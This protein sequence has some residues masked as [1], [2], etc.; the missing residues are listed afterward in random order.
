M[1]HAILITFLL[2]SSAVLDRPRSGTPDVDGAWGGW[3]E[4]AGLELWFQVRF[5]GDG[6]WL[7]DFEA[8]PPAVRA[9]EFAAASG[10]AR[11]VYD[12]PLGSIEFAG[13]VEG[14]R[15]SG[16]VTCAGLD[17]GTFE[18]TRFHDVANERILGRY[19][20]TEGRPLWVVPRSF[21]GARVVELGGP[22]AGFAGFAMPAW[23]PLDD[24]TY[25]AATSATPLEASAAL[26]V[27]DD[28]LRAPGDPS[29]VGTRT[30]GDVRRARFASAGAR[31]EGWL[32]VPPGEGPHPAIVFAH[33]SGYVGADS[34]FDLYV[35]TRLVEELGVAVLRWDKRGVW[36]STGDQALATYAE[37]ADDIA[38]AHAWLRAQEGI[39]PDRVGLGGISQ[40]PSWPI[41]LV[42]AD[43]PDVAFV[44]S[45]SG[46]V[47]TAT[48]TNVF[49]W[50]NRLREDG[51][52]EDD[53]AEAAEFLR[54]ALTW[55][56]STESVDEESL[57]AFLDGFGGARWFADASALAGLDTPLESAVLTRWQSN[58]DL[59]SLESWKRVRC[60]VYLTW[61]E[62][63]R[64]VDATR[65]AARIA[66]IGGGSEGSSFTAMVYPA[67]AG[68][69]GGVLSSPSFFEAL[70]RWFD[71]RVA[72]R[73]SGD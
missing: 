64:L 2:A 53:V 51:Y 50:S 7:D 72:D 39:D 67:P 30:S 13:P 5:E 56:G 60:P 54:A 41:P 48:E 25:F 63:D 24:E 12:A 47:A 33:G 66:A 71:A 17:P 62:A 1:V 22:D 20:D 28:V 26:T 10:E 18:F 9:A 55:V 15:W 68:H 57:Q 32:M 31:L 70:G 46:S 43:D 21:G 38:A 40:A 59:D 19:E 27:V 45:I 69:D 35:C 29:R 3:V 16:V 14:R 36:R 58:W 37:L 61:G 49:N 65:S 6:V 44:I 73:A 8:G 23:L 52:S 34:P 11:F 42:A 4:L